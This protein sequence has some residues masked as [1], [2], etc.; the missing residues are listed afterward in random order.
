MHR[1]ISCKQENHYKFFL[2]ELNNISSGRK[3]EESEVMVKKRKVA[4]QRLL[5]FNSNTVMPQ[6]MR[7][8]RKIRYSKYERGRFFPYSW[9]WMKSCM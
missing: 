6:K 8:G 7:K 9:I 4:K 1:K 3:R 2:I 5:L